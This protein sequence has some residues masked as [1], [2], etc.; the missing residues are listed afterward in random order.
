VLRPVS[1]PEFLGAL[2]EWQASEILQEVPIPDYAHT[3][4]L[5]LFHT[6]ALIGG[7]PE[8]VSHYAKSRDLTA[9]SP[10]YDSLITAYL[11]DV[12]KYAGTANQVQLIRHAITASFREA[13]RRISYE[14]FGNSAYRSRDMSETLR[15]LEKA[16]LL[17]LI[18]PQTGPTLPLSPDLRKKPRLHVLDTGMMN[19]F[20]GLQSEIIQSRDLSAVYKGTMI[21]HLVGQELLAP[22]YLSLSRLHFWVRDKNSSSAE[23]DYLY[24]FEEKLIP[25]EVKS[26]IAGKLKSLHLFMDIAPHSMAV[27]FYAGKLS[28]TEARTSAGKTFH[29]LNLPYYLVS[30]LDAYLHWAK[31]RIDQRLV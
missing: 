13:G 16:F 19:Y 3:T 1:F 4:L 22:Q 6:Y 28:I 17:Q 29:L 27:R 12:E 8:V 14:G 20:A 31:S 21:E 26:G 24:P 2:E 18:F 10:I 30:Q 9:L 25:I 11:D 5:Q 7:M 15:T 23:V